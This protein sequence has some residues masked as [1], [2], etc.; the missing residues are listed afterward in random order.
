MPRRRNR[1]IPVLIT[2][3]AALAAAAMTAPAEVPETMTTPQAT[4]SA[5]VLVAQRPQPEEPDPGAVI[6]WLLRERR[7]RPSE[8]A[9]RPPD[10]TPTQL[11]VSLQEA[12]FVAKGR[13]LFNDTKLSGDG[14]WSCASCHP[15]TAH[16]NNKTYVGVEVVPDGDP[17]GRSTPTMW[18]VGTRSAYSWAGTAPSL[19]AN[20][21]GIIVNRMKGP[22]PSPETLAALVA[23]LRSLGYPRNPSLNADGT[24]SAAAPAA[25]KR[26]YEIFLR[27][28]CKTCHLPPTYD[29]Q[30]V[31]DVFSGGKF[32]VPSLRVVSLT[33]PYFHD[34]RF[35]TLDEVVNYMWEYVQKAGTTEKLTDA[36]LK[37]L[38]E[39]LKIL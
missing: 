33:G 39:F 36:D 23:Y 18:G 4:P 24:P 21:R 30:D 35:A 8:P 16:T 19:Q 34:G 32:K 27:A 28:G 1:L 13:E 3:V 9:T 38:V 7:P 2:C 25:A 6:D 26:G 12:P 29:K 22:E 37:D 5:P 14:K 11:A 31:E 20:V 10:M 17:K 15:N